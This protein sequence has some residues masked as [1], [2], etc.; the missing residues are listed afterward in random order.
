MGSYY[1][2]KFGQQ[3]IC[4]GKS[5]V[6]PIIMSIFTDMDKS[7][8]YQKLSDVY[9]EEKGN[10]EQIEVCKYIAKSTVVKKRLDILGFSL[11]EAEKNLASNIDDAIDSYS[12]FLGMSDEYDDLSK[13]Y[14]NCR[15]VVKESKISDYIEAYKILFNENRK[16]DPSKCSKGML[17]Y[18]T[19]EFIEHSYD[20]GI[21][22]NDIRFTFRVLLECIDDVDEIVLDI[23]DLVVGGYYHFKDNLIEIA[24]NSLTSKYHYDS[25]IIILTEGSSD[26]QIL[27]K[28]FP[29]LFPEYESLY[30]FMDFGL[31]KSSG[32]ASSLVSVIKAFISAGI[33][34]RIVAI[35]DNDTAA[36]VARKSI[37]DIV[38]PDNIRIISYPNYD[39]LTSY[40]TIGPSGRH[41]LNVNEL[42]GSIELYLCKQALLIDSKYSPVQWRGYDTSISA[43]Q[44]EVMHKSQIQKRFFEILNTVSE[45]KDELKKFDWKGIQLIFNEIFQSF[46]SSNT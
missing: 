41:D 6:D 32:G 20:F 25:K 19:N 43:Y 12:L 24:K 27:E 4:S 45:N 7:F 2:L 9:P 37:R 36:R 31:A 17:S 40:P 13:I 1:D 39:F 42:A 3:E 11:V 8:S 10:N 15:T 30:S 18:L 23:S 22:V 14:E 29:L 28:C 5:Y 26:K 35:F 46:E 38:L 44:G 34:N 16:E 21:P 33:K